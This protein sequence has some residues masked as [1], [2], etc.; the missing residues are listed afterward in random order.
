MKTLTRNLLV[1]GLLTF[2]WS[3]QAGDFFD[4]KDCP[5]WE[6]DCNDWPEWTPMYWM[7]EFADSF[8]DDEDY[9]RYGYGPYGAPPMYGPAPY[10]P[11]PG[12]APYGRPLPPPGFA[13][14]PYGRP[15]PPPGFAPAPYGRPVPP[16]GFAPAPYGRPV[17]PRPAPQQ[18]QQQRPPAPQGK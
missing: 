10:G 3:A 6:Y 11:P 1:A 17:P 2:S 8:D 9:W 4:G 18:Q 12:V 14:A 7:E 16:P 5:P 13:P 15:V